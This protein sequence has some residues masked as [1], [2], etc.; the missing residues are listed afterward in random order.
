LDNPQIRDGWD[1]KVIEDISD[2][3]IDTSESNP[4]GIL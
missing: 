2:T 4:F 1:N 3:V